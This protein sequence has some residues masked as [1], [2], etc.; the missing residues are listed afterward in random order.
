MMSPLIDVTFGLAHAREALRR[1]PVIRVR[2]AKR[3]VGLYCR[4]RSRPSAPDPRCREGRPLPRALV[5]AGGAEFLSA[6]ARTLAADI[7]MR[8]VTAS[9]RSGPTRFT[10]SKPCPASHPKQGL[11]WEVARFIAEALGDNVIN[12]QAG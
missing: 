9:W 6:D 11:P 2:D 12:L 7:R 3:L 5:H 10:S 8:A 1:D 4:N